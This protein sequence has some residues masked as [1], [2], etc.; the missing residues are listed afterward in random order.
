MLEIHNLSLVGITRP[1][2]HGIELTLPPHQLVGVIGANGAGKSSLLRCIAAV[3]P[4]LEGQIRFN[5]SDWLGLSHRQR[6]QSLGYLPQTE[7]PEWDIRIDEL[8][9]LTA[10][11][12]REQLDAHLRNYELLAL[13]D[14]RVSQVSGGERQRAL[15]ARATITQPELLICDEPV[16]GLDVAH[17]LTMMQQLKTHAQ[18]RALVLVAIHD[19]AL[20]ARFCDQLLLMHDG[21]LVALGEPFEVLT[22]ANLAHCF[23]VRAEWV[24][25]TN[26]VGWIP[27]PLVTE[28]D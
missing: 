1:R 25:K 10:Q 17:Q 26:G 14:R 19:L 11:H 15:L 23:G 27:T 20:A 9:N 4:R 18:G 6:Q 2:L 8:V 22:E 21:Q 24:C 13:R 3:E 5:S 28:T 12:S 7:T 16:S